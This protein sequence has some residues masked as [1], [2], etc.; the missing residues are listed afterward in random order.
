MF[1]ITLKRRYVIQHINNFKQNNHMIMSVYA[2][3]NI[4]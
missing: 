4:Q 1:L 2:K 3:Y